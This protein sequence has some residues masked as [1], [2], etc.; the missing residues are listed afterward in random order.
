MHLFEPLRKE[1]GSKL[2]NFNLQFVKDRAGNVFTDNLA[3]AFQLN[4]FFSREKR[5][6]QTVLMQGRKM[7]LLLV[8]VATILQLVHCDSKLNLLCYCLRKVCENHRF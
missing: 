6:K 1:S 2:G 7:L 8:I 3:V 4:V 5:I